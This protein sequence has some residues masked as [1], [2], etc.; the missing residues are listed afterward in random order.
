[1]ALA[2]FLVQAAAAA[3]PDEPFALSQVGVF[4]ERYEPTFSTGFAPRAQAPKR[5]HLHVACS[6]TTPAT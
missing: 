6:T 3:T 1:M 2:A 4:Y 5:L